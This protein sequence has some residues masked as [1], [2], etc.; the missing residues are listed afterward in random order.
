MAKS[1]SKSTPKILPQSSKSTR[2]I[3]DTLEKPDLVHCVGGCSRAHWHNLAGVRVGDVKCDHCGGQ[4]IAV[5]RYRQCIYTYN[6]RVDYPM[7]DT[8]YGTEVNYGG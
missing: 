6:G 7:G 3:T 5:W 2:L 1:S 4:K 8:P